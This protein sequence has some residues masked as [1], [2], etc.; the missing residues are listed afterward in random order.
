MKDVDR[1]VK[2][3]CYVLIPGLD[4]EHLIKY[5][6]RLDLTYLHTSK[7]FLFTNEQ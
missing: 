2:S 6:R 7:V 3:N 1:L 4:I 5:K